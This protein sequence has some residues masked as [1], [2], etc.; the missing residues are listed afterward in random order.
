MSCGDDILHMRP[1]AKWCSRDCQHNSNRGMLRAF[2]RAFAQ[3]M[4]NLQ[5]KYINRDKTWSFDGRYEGPLNKPVTTNVK[6]RKDHGYHPMPFDVHVRPMDKKYSVG[7]P[8]DHDWAT[9]QRAFPHSQSMPRAYKSFC[10]NCF[11]VVV[12]G[13]TEL[14]VTRGVYLPIEHDCNSVRVYDLHG[15]LLE[16]KTL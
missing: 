6:V 2:N 8:Q 16:V 9:K 10:A 3:V 13:A 4:R 11:E 1:N 7:T 5:F 12:N 15:K 14:R